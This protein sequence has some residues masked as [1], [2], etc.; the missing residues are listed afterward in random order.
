MEI[1]KLAHAA[2]VDGVEV[3]VDA[4]LMAVGSGNREV[5]KSWG[6]SC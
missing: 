4:L 6:G 3:D 5:R 2:P 1:S